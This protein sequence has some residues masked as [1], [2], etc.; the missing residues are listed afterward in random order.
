M[1]LDD[2]KDRGYNYEGVGSTETGDRPPG[3]HPMTVSARIGTGR[4]EFDRAAEALLHWKV[5]QVVGVRLTASVER[6]KV[7]A[8]SL[9][10]L[11]PGP[12]AIAVPCRVVWLSE[13]PDRVGYA[14]GTLDGHPERGEE[15]FV[16]TLA[17]DGAVTFTITAF[18]RP[19]TW[20]ARLG[21]PVTRALQRYIA[22]RYVAQL[23]S[24]AA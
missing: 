11:G 15:A 20:Y 18:S 4:L 22:G 16:V 24:L 7:G 12:L 9:G 19:A 23:R 3:Y 8:V 5:Q 17:A 10:R 14:Y 6:V 2:L 13:E 21:G 1:R